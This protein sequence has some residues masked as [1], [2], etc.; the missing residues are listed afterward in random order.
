ML[1]KVEDAIV[2]VQWVLGTKCIVVIYVNG[3][4]GGVS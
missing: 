4:C 1:E 2:E 3:V